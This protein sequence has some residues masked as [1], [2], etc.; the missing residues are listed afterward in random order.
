MSVPPLTNQA[1]HS[2]PPRHLIV[3]G[4]AGF[5]GSSLID[6]WLTQNSG[7][8][9]ALDNFNDFYDPAIKH[10]NLQNARIIFK[11]RLHIET[12]D[13]TSS[14]S[15]IVDRILRI[16][17]KKSV[18]FVPDE[19]CII[20]LAGYAGV[21]SSTRNP[22]LYAHHNSVGS[23]SMLE[24]CR[25]LGIRHFINASSSSVYGRSST[26]PFTET[27]CNLKP[28]SPYA[29][30][31]LASEIFCNTYAQLYNLKIAS[32]RFFT[33]YGPRQRPDLAI[34]KFTKAIAELKPVT[35]YGNPLGTRDYTYIDDVVQGIL[36]T[37][38]W[39]L[40]SVASDPN[41]SHTI[42]N[43][44]SQRPIPLV[45]VISSIESALQLKSAK[46]WE[47]LPDA[48]VTHTYANIELA[49]TTIGYSPSTDFQS[50]IYRFVQWFKNHVDQ[51]TYS[52][53]EFL[54]TPAPTVAIQP[55]T[56]P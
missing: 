27:E 35:L 13:V 39:L 14:P 38:L 22:T 8:L 6:A 48:D 11:E 19:W 43:L 30:T 16:F 18:L 49:K 23:M 24:C 29:A 37:W 17:N 50:G 55:E 28:C 5:I 33:V 34:Y 1:D 9:I 41:G 4:G 25:L 32:L 47:P 40:G 36:Q 21:R 10:Q 44:G 20:H 2:S 26:I 7:F 56:L 46:I 51:K 15:V 12:V 45:E 52:S 53:V 42:L 54:T 31:Q 3:T